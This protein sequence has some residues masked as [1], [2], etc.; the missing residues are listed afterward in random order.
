M[1]AARDL[2]DEGTEC[3]GFGGDHPR[4]DAAS[5]GFRDQLADGL[6]CSM[7]ELAQQ[8]AAVQEEWSQQL[9]YGERPETVAHF[10]HDFLAQEGAEDN[11]ALGRPRRAE[12]STGTGESK[13]I[14]ALV[15]KR[16]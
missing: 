5:G 10:L 8:L 1:A 4:A 14:L 2:R 13:E 15:S 11:P 3:S 16:C 6:P 9:R 12:A 7:T